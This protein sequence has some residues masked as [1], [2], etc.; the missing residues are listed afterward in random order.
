M[1]LKEA[2]E[3]VLRLLPKYEH[4]FTQEAATPACLS[5]GL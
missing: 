4:V 3:W 2:N 5:T 1:S